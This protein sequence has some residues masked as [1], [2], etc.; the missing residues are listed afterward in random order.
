MK[1]IT[2]IIRPEKLNTVQEALADMNIKG[3]TI[4]DVQGYGQQKGHKEIFRGVE[5]DVKFNQKVKIELA[6]DNDNWQRV[7]DTIASKARSDKGKI[8]DGKIFVFDIQE[9]IRI[10]TGEKGESAL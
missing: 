8:G 6:V 1:Y 3:L 5:Y 2:A 7:I 9:A 10:R 4:S